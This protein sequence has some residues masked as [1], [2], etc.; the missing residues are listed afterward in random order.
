MVGVGVGSAVGWDDGLKSAVVLSDEQ[1]V[2]EKL[3]TGGADDC[4]ECSNGNTVNENFSM[5][6]S[7][8]QYYVKIKPHNPNEN[9]VLSLE[10]SN[11]VE[12]TLD[13]TLTPITSMP[14]TAIPS[15][16]PTTVT[17]N[18]SRYPTRSPTVACPSIPTYQPS[19]SPVEATTESPTADDLQDTT[20]TSGS[21][22][23]EPTRGPLDPGQTH[24]P[25][26]TPTTSEPTDSTSSPTTSEPTPS[27]ANTDTTDESVMIKITLTTFAFAILS[28]LYIS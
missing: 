8:G 1:S 23:M 19:L 28:T 22:T 27:P 6:L 17:S 7:N 3:Y 5:P 11:C 26:M 16:S 20:T 2:N 14:T 4:G 9:C 13:P 21:N 10:I 18:P 24:S 25:T 12:G 15:S